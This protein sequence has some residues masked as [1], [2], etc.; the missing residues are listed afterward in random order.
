MNASI[1]PSFKSKKPIY[2]FAV[3]TILIIFCN[4]AVHKL[5]L[6]IPTE[7]T[8]LLDTTNA[9]I[10]GT[11]FDLTLII[12]SHYY[13]LIARKRTSAVTVLPVAI[14]GFWVAYL[15]VPNHNIEAFQYIKYAIYG[16]EGIFLFIEIAIGIYLLKK[17]P[18]FITNYR[19][20]K[21]TEPFQTFLLRKVFEKTF[22]Y[23]KV[24]NYLVLD[25][26]AIY[27]GLFAWNHKK[28]THF[29]NQ[30][31]FTYHQKAGYF[32]VFMMFVHAMLIEIIAVHML[33]AQWS[34]AGAWAVTILDIYAL[35]FIIADYQAIRL[36]PIVC[37]NNQL[38][39]QI[40]LR[41]GMELK[42]SNIKSIQPTKTNK[43]T[44]K[45]EKP[46]FYITLPEFYEEEPAF[47]IELHEPVTAY[48]PLGKKEIT[49]IY[50]NIDDRQNFYHLIS[51]ASHPS[52]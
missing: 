5:P 19:Y 20:F 1:T 6:S 48:T 36:S 11:L 46:C 50:A 16:F 41:R 4:Y 10:W 24:V 44:R 7:S 3:L 27:Y 47:E 33:V 12:P 52:N 51:E 9:M 42:I 28:N 26:S 29:E 23:S 45:K 8:F 25:L 14:A 31:T 38:L 21:R 30:Q 49:K 13:F 18:A 34:I 15:I 17:L 43:A 37:R 22:G 39:I 40:G 32:G 35:F 2:V